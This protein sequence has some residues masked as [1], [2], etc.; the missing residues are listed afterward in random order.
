MKNYKIIH[1]RKHIP[2]EDSTLMEDFEGLVNA[3][4][5][6]K[7]KT[8]F[9][10]RIA[11]V[12][13]AIAGFIA[14]TLLGIFKDHEKVFFNNHIASSKI[15][16]EMQN[17]AVETG[18]AIKLNQ[19]RENAGK[20]FEAPENIENEGPEKSTA[21]LSKK[22]VASKQSKGEIETG[23]VQ[24]RPIEGFPAL[25]QYFDENLIYP[26]EI[27]KENVQGKV[28]VKFVIDKEG[29]PSAFDVEL[30]LHQVMDSLA[31][32]LVR[33][34]PLWEPARL[35]GRPIS[36]THRIPLFFQ[37]TDKSE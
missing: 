36:S 9:N 26:E 27:A 1:D 15:K 6:N 12:V 33:N 17:S 13:I 19:V 18:P 20:S 11:R 24:A 25:Y 5:F 7:S 31:I 22:D 21:I 28:I 16:K 2:F 29:V 35:N 10:W 4:E 23:F 32:D 14:L 34:M 30:S 3:Y 37:I 8:S